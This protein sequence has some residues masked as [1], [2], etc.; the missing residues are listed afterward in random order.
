VLECAQTNVCNAAILSLLAKP[1]KSQT[2]SGGNQR[3]RGAGELRLI[4]GSWRGRKLRFPQ[5]DGLRPTSDRIRE[6]LFNWLAPHIND[7]RCADLFA[8]SGAL[9]L[10][11]LSRG[12]RMCD[13]I[14]PS[15]SASSQISEHLNTLNASDKGLCHRRT[16]LEFLQ[17]PP[18]PYDLVFVDP[19]FRQEMIPGV[20]EAL[21]AGNWLAPGAIVYIETAS[22]EILPQL[23]VHWLIHREKT[24]GGVSYRTFHSSGA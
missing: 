17:G 1:T 5:E 12:A 23:P 10:E 18:S 3:S 19:P 22:D 24:S 9:G 8:G 20:C 6:T 13:F 14:E 15:K 21:D 4:G 2:K 7:A 11:A 16:A